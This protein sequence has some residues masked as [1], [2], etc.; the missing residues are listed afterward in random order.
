MERKI[1][2][3]HAHEHM[4]TQL[5]D[6][7]ETHY[8]S[9]QCIPL[10]EDLPIHLAIVDV[11]TLEVEPLLQMCH[12]PVSVTRL[13]KCKKFHFKDDRQRSMGATLLIDYLLCTHYGLREQAVA[14][15]YTSAG[16]P[17]LVG[18]PDLHFSL[19]HAGQYAICAFSDQV[20]LGIDIEA[21]VP[22][23]EAVASLCMDEDE[24]QSLESLPPEQHAATFITSWCIK[25]AVLKL[26][27]VGL[28]MNLFPRIHITAQG[29]E[30]ADNRYPDINMQ[31]IPLPG[32]AASL[33]WYAT[34]DKK[35][36]QKV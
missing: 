9:V 32:Y 4:S 31:Q 14:Y 17:S 34:N 24:R 16:K 33:A 29:C 21:L 22:Y 8:A 15:T 11:S 35:N 12:P 10:P 25:E 36:S 27:G 1:T 13:E 6:W 18:N 20:E 5:P 30:L 28:S 2:L 26:S 19:S 3:P 7:M 23:D